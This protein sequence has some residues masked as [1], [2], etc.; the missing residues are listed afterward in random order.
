MYRGVK[1][2]KWASRNLEKQK[3]NVLKMGEK[4]EGKKA[5][6]E[7]TG[8][9]FSLAIMAARKHWRWRRSAA[10]KAASVAAL[11]SVA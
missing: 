8:G 5:G 11:E 3:E 9:G 10:S 1:W 6:D 4:E 7:E 2:R